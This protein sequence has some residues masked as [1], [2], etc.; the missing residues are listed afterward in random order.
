MKDISVAT[1]SWGSEM[2]RLREIIGLYL[3][4]SPDQVHESTEIGRRG[5]PGS[6]Q[7]HRMYTKMV[8][9]GFEIAQPSRIETY[10]DLLSDL[11]GELTNADSETDFPCQSGGG[12]QDVRP[13]SH[14]RE[15]LR[16]SVGI[17]LEEIGNLPDVSEFSNHIFYIENFSASEI[18]LAE[19]T[20]D[21]RRRFAGL[22]SLKEAICKADNRFM[23][24]PFKELEISYSDAG[25]PICKGFSLS[26]S[27]TELFAIGIAIRDTSIVKYRYSEERSVVALR[28]KIRM[29]RRVVFLAVC[30]IVLISVIAIILT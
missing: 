26:S 25:E 19:A 13:A 29:L 24:T 9:E 7:R 1:V 21:P 12:S 27:Y 8:S 6:I 11:E 22:F 20:G 23:H 5:I 18:S 10:G 16:Y 3:G 28:V 30:C 4:I 2:D 14:R 15:E 17:D